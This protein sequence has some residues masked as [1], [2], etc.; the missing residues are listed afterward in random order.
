MRDVIMIVLTP[1]ALTIGAAVGT[2]R[3]RL[4]WRADIGLQKPALRGALLYG[5]VFVVLMA[6]HEALSRWL[7]GDAAA[8]DWRERYSGAALVARV[9][10]A[11]AIYPIAEEFFFRGFLLAVI[12]RKAGVV[13]AVVATAA[14]FTALH[15]VSGP[16]L[17]ALQIFADGVFFAIARLRTGSLYVPIACHVLGN[18]LAVAQRLF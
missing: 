11:S 16:S 9:V 12:G 7:G 8:S 6:M 18:S 13:I 10:F 17:G 14:L 3:N 2:F 5:A 1:L 4:E 15:S